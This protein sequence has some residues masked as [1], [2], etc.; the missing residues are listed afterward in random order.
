MSST[1]GN[2][3]VFR[4]FVMLVA[5]FCIFVSNQPREAAAESLEFPAPRESTNA[6][7]HYQRACLFLNSVD[8]EQRELL[9]KPIWQVVTS[10]S[11]DEDL[12]NV[13][14]VLVPSRHAIRSALVGADQTEA[15]FGLD[16]RQ[17][18]VASYLPHSELMKELGRLV[19]LHGMQQQSTGDWKNAAQTYA[20]GLRMGRHM[21]HQTTLSEALAGVEILETIYFSLGQWAVR[22]PDRQLVDDVSTM[23]NAMAGDMVNPARTMR[24]E[25]SISKMRLDALE[26]AFPDGPWAEMVLEGLGADMPNA[27]RQ[28]MREAAIKAAGEIGAPADVFDSKQTFTT[29]MN[30]LRGS[31]ADLARESAVCLTLR[32]PHS[33]REGQQVYAK[34][35]TKLPAT[36]RRSALNPA[37][38]AA[39]FAVHQAELDMLRLVLAIS[40]ER[41]DEGYPAS[42]DAV[43]NRLGDDHLTSP[44]DG[45]EYLYKQLED[46]NGFALKVAEAKVGD[47][48]LP[49]MT[50]KYAQPA[51]AE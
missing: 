6:A 39:F 9:R 17:Y 21:T 28:S 46:G 20:A 51:A 31:Y 23:V 8:Y 16:V 26:A 33:I 2:R 34:Y 44:F 19:A 37:Q 14:R 48:D 10:E 24:F 43:R 49:S 3:T 29:Y 41:T 5:A 22:C 18:M 13:D 12:A 50:F 47:I 35:E 11:T 27:D 7:I 36:E 1:L 42:L 15:D 40:A 25:A 30:K 45:S 32:P 38:A 4:A